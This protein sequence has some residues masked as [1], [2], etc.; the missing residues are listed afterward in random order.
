MSDKKKRLLV[1]FSLDAYQA[2]IV[3]AAEASVDRGQPVSMTQ[4]VNELVLE[5]LKEVDK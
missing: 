3:L 5:K 1:S 4:I 2:L